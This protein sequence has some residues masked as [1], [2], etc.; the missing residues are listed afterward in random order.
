[1]ERG[2]GR[3][4]SQAR[5]SGRSPVLRVGCNEGLSI[6]RQIDIGG[7]AN[8]E[9]NKCNDVG[10][11]DTSDLRVIGAGGPSEVEERQYAHEAGD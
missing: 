11:D 3:L 2:G 5:V 4:S 1:M 8:D 6:A 10:D 7:G 9:A